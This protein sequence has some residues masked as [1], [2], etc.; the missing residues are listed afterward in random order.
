MIKGL[1]LKSRPLLIK[2]SAV[3]LPEGSYELGFVL[4]SV[5][6]DVFSL[7]IVSCRHFL[8]QFIETHCF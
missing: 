1:G 8:V 6:A 4:R 5:C 2:P 7:P 3:E